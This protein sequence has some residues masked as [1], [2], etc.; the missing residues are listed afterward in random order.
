MI[1]NENLIINNGYI[2]MC[3]FVLYIFHVCAATQLRIPSPLSTHG[4]LFGRN[5]WTLLVAA[6]LQD[7]S[8]ECFM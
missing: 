5:G 1:C 7:A 8:G 4:V 6:K 3:F 2:L